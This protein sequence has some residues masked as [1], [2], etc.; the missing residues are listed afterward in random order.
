MAETNRAP[1]P[2]EAS[3]TLR[4]PTASV[5]LHWDARS[6]VCRDVRANPSAAPL[7]SSAFRPKE[8]S[9]TKRRARPYWT[10]GEIGLV[11]G[12]SPQAIEWEQAA[13]GVTFSLAPALL[14]DPVRAVLSGAS[15]ELVWVPGPEQSKALLPAVYPVLLV[16]T[17]AEALQ[18]ERVTIVP[19]LLPSDPLLQHIAL[20]LQAAIEGAGVV[21]QL[22]S[23]SLADA[24]VIHFFRRY[25]AARPLSEVSGG[26]SA[27]KLRHAT[28][29]IQAHLAQAISLTQ[30]AAVGQTSPAHFARLFKHATGL[31]PHR[32]VIVRRMEEAKRLLSETEVSLSEIA[33][34]VGCADQSHFSALFRRHVGMTPKAYRDRTRTT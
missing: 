8:P 12:I 23:Q 20:M 24:L 31:A 7:P 4:P 2:G 33:L 26:L 13:A 6:G 14:A 18:A 21:G 9:T 1:T 30:L 3:A 27:Y 11:P 16:H 22:Y 29:Y 10:T 17:L 19:Y 34:Q 15:G 5:V 28:V 32:Y 25:G